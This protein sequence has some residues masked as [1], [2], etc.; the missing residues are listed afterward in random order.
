MKKYIF[1]T[2]ATAV[3]AASPAIAADDAGWYVGAGVGNFDANSDM[4]YNGKDWQG[5][6]FGYK[7]FGGYQF[8]K[9]LAVE[10]E[11]VDGG[12]PSD[13][14][15]NPSFP[16]DRLRASVGVTGFVGSAVGIWPIGESFNLFG[17]LGFIYW[18]ADGSGKIRDEDGTIVKTSVGEDGTDF[19]WGVGGTWNFSETFGVR[20]E[21]QGFELSNFDSVDFASASIVWRF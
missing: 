1:A 15:R 9:W 4:I 13:N 17:K 2:V 14:F 5:S 19:A 16:D 20:A 10:A 21:Y 11:Y 6:D 12:E 7:F 3:L 8:M 18:D